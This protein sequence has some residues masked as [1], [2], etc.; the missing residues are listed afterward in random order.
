[1]HGGGGGGGELI[2]NNCYTCLGTNSHTICSTRQWINIQL[3]QNPCF[4]TARKTIKSFS[5]LGYG[6]QD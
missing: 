1:M 5:V 2:D 6:W 3:Q 4:K